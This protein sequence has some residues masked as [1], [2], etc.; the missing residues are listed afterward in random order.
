MRVR[1]IE[2]ARSAAM[3]T[4]LHTIAAPSA[5]T[6][7]FSRTIKGNTVGVGAAKVPKP[8]SAPAVTRSAPIAPRTRRTK[9]HQAAAVSPIAIATRNG[10]HAVLC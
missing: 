9:S 5:R 7:S 4:S 10:K 1:S 3:K 8:Q 2:A 6:R